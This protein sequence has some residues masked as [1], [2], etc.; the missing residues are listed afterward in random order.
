MS[1]YDGGDEKE[2]RKQN[3]LETLIKLKILM[4]NNDDN[5]N[6]ELEDFHIRRKIVRDAFTEAHKNPDS[7]SAIRQSLY[8]EAINDAAKDTDSFFGDDVDFDDWSGYASE[9]PEEEDED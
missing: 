1:K 9:T 3:Q 8:A 7:D 6:I 4:D 2:S 5:S